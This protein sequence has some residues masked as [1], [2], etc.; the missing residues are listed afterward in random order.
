M[1]SERHAANRQEFSRAEIIAAL[2]LAPCHI[3]GTHDPEHT[4]KYVCT[5]QLK[6]ALNGLLD[7]LGIT[8]D[9]L[10]RRPHP[11]PSSGK[12]GLLEAAWVERKPITFTVDV[13]PGAS[14]DNY[15]E[16]WEAACAARPSTDGRFR[17]NGITE[18]MDEP[19]MVGHW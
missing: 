7:L 4:P 6:D 12:K 5:Y 15:G 16:A 8:V 14:W 11:W 10:P 17:V 18:G 19:I 13:L 9:D 2:A 1:T 3:T